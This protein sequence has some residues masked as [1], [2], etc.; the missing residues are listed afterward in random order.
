MSIK[1]VT[2]YKGEAHITAKQTG[3]FN[4]SVVGEG[5]YVLAG[6]SQLAASVVTANL[7]RIADGDV[8][9]QGRHITIEADT[10]EEVAIGNGLSGMNRNDLIC[11]RYSKNTESGVESASLVVI[12]GTSTEGTASDPSYKTGNI[13]TGGTT[14]DMPLYRVVLNGLEISKVT[15][16][17]K[18]VRS[19]YEL[20]TVAKTAS[21]NIK[22]LQDD[23]SNLES[24]KQGNLNITAL[25][26]SDSVDDL[27]DAFVVWIDKKA[28]QGTHPTFSVST[29][30]YILLNFRTGT[31]GANTGTRVQIAI[32]YTTSSD[33]RLMTRMYTNSQWYAWSDATSDL[34]SA[35]SNIEDE[36]R[37][38]I[39]T[40]QTDVAGLKSSKQN[41]LGKALTSTESVDDLKDS[42]AAWINKETINGTHPTFSINYYM[43]LNFS[44]GGGARVQI[45]FPLTVVSANARPEFR[46]YTNSKWYAWI[47]PFDAIDEA[48]AKAQSSAQSYAKDLVET[49]EGKVTTNTSDI[50]ALITAVNGKILPLSLEEVKLS[51]SSTVD[52]QA[53]VNVSASAT[54]VSGATGYMTIPYEFG[55]CSP[56]NVS[57]SGGK[58]QARL[59]NNSGGSHTLSC[60]FYVIAYKKITG[61]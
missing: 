1:I 35:F 49:L 17:F 19:I 56:S 10:Y 43:L 4:S 24:T 3:A 5:S 39:A 6:G 61:L 34:E 7:I 8:L 32:P 26:T 59:T 41:S 60:N 15:K 2:G 50:S 21:N 54:S 11:L 48:I 27:K 31:G 9:H 46:L 42:Y 25:T 36:L 51:S 57:V 55:Y 52:D 37:D 13:L 44:N 28:V 22:T 18:T 40:L 38:L 12:Q 33:A 53:Y 58:L 30:Y 23:V 45:A 14:V 20:D 47:S 16:L 29:N